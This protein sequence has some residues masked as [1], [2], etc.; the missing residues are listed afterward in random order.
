LFAVRTNDPGPLLPKLWSKGFLFGFFR[1]SFPFVA[2]FAT[3]TASVFTLSNTFHEA[4]HVRFPVARPSSSWLAWLCIVL[5]AYVW[6]V[7]HED[8]RFPAVS[9]VR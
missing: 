7:F 1:Q 4:I 2:L 5:L 6:P 8:H 3:R 9:F